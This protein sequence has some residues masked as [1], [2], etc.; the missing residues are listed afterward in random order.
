MRLMKIIRITTAFFYLGLF[1]FSSQLIAQSNK[2]I[3]LLDANHV[4]LNGDSIK[5]NSL[6]AKLQK[7]IKERIVSTCKRNIQVALTSQN[8]QPAKAY[9][10]IKNT[11]LLDSTFL[12]AHAVLVRLYLN[13][14]DSTQALST[15]LKAYEATKSE[16]FLPI[17]AALELGKEEDSSYQKLNNIELSDIEASAK[18]SYVKGLNYYYNES[19]DKAMVAFQENPDD[20]LN[21]LGTATVKLLHQDFEKGREDMISFLSDSL[22]DNIAAYQLALSYYKRKDITATLKYLGEALETDSMML[23]A[24]YMRAHVFHEIGQTSNALNDFKVCL[25]K[26]YKYQEALNNIAVCNYELEKYD[27]AEQ[28]ASKAI[29]EN[30]ATAMTY[31]VRGNSKEMINKFSDACEDWYKAVDLGMTDILPLIK[32]FCETHSDTE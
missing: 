13:K 23:T 30:H 10:F 20:K 26:S 19:L 21:A 7:D 6:D 12:P 15:A 1:F 31:L 29:N 8:K 28:V 2:R 24:Y 14:K 4:L 32:N 11:L 3:K 17:I 22:F 16:K 5:I 9:H 25:E 18:L 27:E